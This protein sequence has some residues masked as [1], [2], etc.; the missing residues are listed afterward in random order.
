MTIFRSVFG[1]NVGYWQ[2]RNLRFEPQMGQSLAEGGPLVTV[3]DPLDNNAE[4][5]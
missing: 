2:W 1:F 5:C 3:G 4:K